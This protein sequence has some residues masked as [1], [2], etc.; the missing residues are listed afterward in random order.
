MHSLHTESAVANRAPIVEPSRISRVW[1]HPIEPRSDL[2]PYAPDDCRAEAFDYAAAML[3]R[4]CQ[5]HGWALR[6]KWSATALCASRS[7][8]GRAGSKAG[9]AAPPP[10]SS[11]RDGQSPS[12]RMRVCRAACADGCVSTCA[13]CWKRSPIRIRGRAVGEFNEKSEGR[14][15]DLT[16]SP[17]PAADVRS[18][19]ASRAS[20]DRK[21]EQGK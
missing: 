3:D 13:M 20:I 4:V 10:R 16:M 21:T 17:A 12:P 6:A 7:A 14:P 11:V 9:S 18:G 15:K 5:Q 19:V 2:N 8:G 1:A